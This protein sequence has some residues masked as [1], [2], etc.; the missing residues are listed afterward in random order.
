MPAGSFFSP[1]SDCSG[2]SAEERPIGTSG[3]GYACRNEAA[4]KTRFAMWD[5]CEG[6]CSANPGDALSVRNVPPRGLS[7]TGWAL[8]NLRSKVD[9]RGDPP[10]WGHAAMRILFLALDVNLA[11]PKGDAVH[12]LELV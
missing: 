1:G 8:F 2:R 12:V 4:R 9:H 3:R 7:R 5:L 11:A 10:H 6:S